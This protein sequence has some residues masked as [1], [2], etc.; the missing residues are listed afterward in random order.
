MTSMISIDNLS[1]KFRLYKSPR[2]RLME[3]FGLGLHHDAFWALRHI[4]LEI[5]RGRA[6][7]LIG[8]NGA[9]KSTLLKL[10]TGTLL[11][12]EGTITTR[13]RI[14]ALL[15]LG[16]GFHAEFTGRQNIY[17]NGQLLG[18][19]HD[20]IQELEREIIDFSELGP[21]IEQPLRTYS[22][23]MVMRLGFSI[24]SAMRPEILIVDEALSVG[25]ARFSQKCTRRIL[26][27]RES[28]ATILF[29]SHDPTA[30]SSLCDEAVLLSRGTITT[31]GT[32]REV[33][34]EY[35]ALIAAA[36]EGNQTMTVSWVGRR[37][38]GTDGGERRSGTFEA[39]LTRLQVLDAHG[40]P[41][42]V[43]TTGDTLVLRLSV[44]FLAAVCNP[45]FGFMIRDRLG[46]DLFGTNTHLQGINLGQFAT[47]DSVDLEVRVPLQLGYGDY[48]V[49]VAIHSEDNHLEQCYDWTDQAAVFRIREVEKPQWSGMM[50][51]DAAITHRPRRA[52]PQEIRENLSR[53]FPDLAPVVSMAGGEPNPWLGGFMGVGDDPARGPH[54]WM[55]PR[56]TL[57]APGT[58]E[59]L[60]I[61]V[62]PG[63]RDPATLATVR[64]T[65]TLIGH[66]DLYI[67]TPRDGDT[68][69][70][71]P[72]PRG[73]RGGP[74]ALEIAVTPSVPPAVAEPI[75]GSAV[76]I[77]L[78]VYHVGLT[79][80]EGPLA[81]WPRQSPD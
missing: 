62:H 69:L 72:I 48:S 64:I 38:N 66:D 9:G 45:T 81:A 59:C 21:F 34:Q 60:Y 76:E 4:S 36:G 70:K 18:L 15:E 29:V 58:G 79:P 14:A 63:L 32:P 19:T 78:A 11:P 27:F 30:V 47:G 25:D 5:P 26:Q 6:V 57:V 12:T 61:A 17:I 54:R 44:L 77:G 73:L 7:A 42:E 10:I 16:T 80:P 3:M 31:R 23:G 2:R 24:A 33:L 56:A 40:T 68:V 39:L 52:N 37:E 22:S 35:N 51:H 20:E 43:H 1:K 71:V 49:A 55:R 67:Y 8:A 53:L 13:G 46:L 65:I 75:I 28:G 50:R 41:T 74:M